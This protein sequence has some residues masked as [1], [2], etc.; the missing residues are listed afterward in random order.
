[1]SKLA[2]SA[3]SGHSATVHVSIDIG[4]RGPAI[5]ISSGCATG[6]DVLAWGV[7][8]IRSGRADAAIVGATESPIFPMS[9]ATACSLGILSKRNDEPDKAMRPFDRH[10]DGIGLAEGAVGVVLEREDPARARGAQIL[11]EVAGFGS[12]AEGIN[13][14]IL[15]SQGEAL[16][17]AIR[18]AMDDAG[19]G[20]DDIDHIQSHGVSLEMYDRCETSACKAALGGAAYRIPI[21]AVKS[22]I[23]QAYSAGG[24]LGVAAALMAIEEGV[25]PPTMNLE[26]PDPACDLDF[27]PNRSRI[28]DV[29]TALVCA[30]SFGGTHSATVLRR[31]S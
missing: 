23:G 26:D 14:L 18:Q 13:P 3:F 25:I 30:I 4:V 12:A 11:G 15:D 7:T 21:T 24:L 29:N 31:A 28:N 16:A 27:V 2:S 17:R 9:F 6:L 5:T 8:Q 10:R 1:V 19:I 22:M 20:P